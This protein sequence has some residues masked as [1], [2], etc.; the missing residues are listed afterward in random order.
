MFKR[1]NDDFLSRAR[2][3]FDTA[4]SAGTAPVIGV[5]AV[6]ALVL[7]IGAGFVLSIAD[8]SVNSVGNKGIVEDIWTSLMRTLDPGTMGSDNGWTLRLV[9][10][11]VTICGI[12]I[13]S[14][15]IGLLSHGVDRSLDRLGK[16]RS[17]VHEKG[18]V[19]ILG[20]SSHV[21][22]IVEQ[23][24]QA[25]LF[26]RSARVVLLAPLSKEFIED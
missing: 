6:A 5:L 7:V 18:H 14:T 10:L 2:Y 8:V 4:F 23:L 11:S 9:T 19:V 17:V 20:W 26:E 16:G 3:R 24:V 13:L 25:N 1:G 12:L 21:P 15:L 22:T